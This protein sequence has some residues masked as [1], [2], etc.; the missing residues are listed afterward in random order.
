M[1]P[2]PSMLQRS[3]ALFF[4]GHGEGCLGTSERSRLEQ[5]ERRSTFS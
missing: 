4:E 2:N 1:L 3:Y 5:L